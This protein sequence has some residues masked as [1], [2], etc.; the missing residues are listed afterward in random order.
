MG[1]VKRE[2]PLLEG[3]RFKADASPLSRRKYTAKKHSVQSVFTARQSSVQPRRIRHLQRNPAYVYSRKRS[4]K[5]SSFILTVIRRHS[6]PASAGV[7]HT[8]TF[9]VRVVITSVQFRCMSAIRSQSVFRA[10]GT[11][12]YNGNALAGDESASVFE[13]EGGLNKVMLQKVSSAIFAGMLAL[14]LTCGLAR[15]QASDSDKQGSAD[16]S[17]KI[18]GQSMTV[19]GCLTK[20]A[21]EKDEY[22]I[23]G[24]D[25]KTWGLKSTSVKLADHLNH[26]ITVTGK[27]TKEGHENEAGD[28]NVS[29]LKMVSE[30]CQ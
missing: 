25:G 24:E 19:T 5:I 14:V 20:D 6:F 4:E 23:K 26:K 15:A 7:L 11:V 29:D 3:F 13:A 22:V 1:W 18:V 12:R 10:L 21:K 28:L 27:V 2:I 8:H 30:S 9:Y 16:R 17:A